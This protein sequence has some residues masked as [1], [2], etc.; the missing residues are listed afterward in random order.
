MTSLPGYK[1]RSPL[2]DTELNAAEVHYRIPQV[3]LVLET[4]GGDGFAKL[5]E[6]NGFK[7]HRQWHGSSGNGASGGGAHSIVVWLQEAG[8][9]SAVLAAV[10]VTARAYIQRRKGNQVTLYR[11]NGKK[12]AEIK[13]DMSARDIERVVRAALDL[14]EPEAGTSEAGEEAS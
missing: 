14:P 11:G 2:F 13:G 1:N 4:G 7:K 8:G 10:S 5:L 9:V 3:G 6:A 12:L